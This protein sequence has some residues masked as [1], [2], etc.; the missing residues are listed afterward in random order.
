[1]F[2]LHLQYISLKVRW[3]NKNPI[4]LFCLIDR[5]SLFDLLIFN[6]ISYVCSSTMEDLQYGQDLKATLAYL[7]QN[8]TYQS[9]GLGIPAHRPLT[10]EAN[11]M[12]S[13][14]MIQRSPR[15]CRQHLEVAPEIH[16]PS[17]GLYRH[18][19][20]KSGENSPSMTSLNRYTSEPQKSPSPKK[21]RGRSLRKNSLT[22]SQTENYKRNRE[23]TEGLNST[24]TGSFRH[25]RDRAE[26]LVSPNRA[27]KR[28][29][30]SHSYTTSLSP[31]SLAPPHH[32]TARRKASYDPPRSPIHLTL[33]ERD[34]NVSHSFNNLQSLSPSLHDGYSLRKC[35]TRSTSLMPNSGCPQPLQRE[36]PLPPKRSSRR[37][38]SSIETN[39]LTPP[40]LHR[41]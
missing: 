12:D 15:P 9:A 29:S 6:A 2:F 17:P 35:A 3:C 37:Y 33:S 22:S 38:E 31:M 40:S 11:V 34:S 24:S 7:T 36:S 19:D 1:M 13:S 10:A 23:T 5:S 28:L 30:L 20:P 25:S 41:I 18:R 8:P 16:S 39:Y 26:F 27:P 14:R 4:F 32:A 21:Y